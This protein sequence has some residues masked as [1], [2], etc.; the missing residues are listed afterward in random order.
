MYLCDCSNLNVMFHK[1]PSCPKSGIKVYAAI[2][3]LY[4]KS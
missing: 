2:D 1:A 3:F 4:L